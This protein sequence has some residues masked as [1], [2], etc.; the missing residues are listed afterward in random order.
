MGRLKWHT[1]HIIRDA[2]TL[3]RLIELTDE[4]C[5]ALQ[6][7][8]KNRIPFGITPYYV[9]LMDHGMDHEMDHEMDREWF[10]K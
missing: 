9:S 4:E 8:R 1:R 2:D 5:Q 7:A 10:I 3:S 6:E